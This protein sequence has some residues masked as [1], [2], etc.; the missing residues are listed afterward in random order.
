MSTD[1]ESVLAKIDK[2]PA[3][4]LLTVRNRIDQKLNS[5]AVNNS[6]GHTNSDKPNLLP[7]GW[8]T[9]RGKNG[10]PMYG[11]FGNIGPGHPDYIPMSGVHYYTVEETEE[12]LAKMFTPEERAAIDRV[13]LNNL[14]EPPIPL[15]Q[16]LNE[17]REDRF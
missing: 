17:D 6:N 8:Q 14:P 3:S 13:D 5:E 7:E 12:S 1:L 15:S 16:S 9:L 10:L 4:D 11:R 2:L